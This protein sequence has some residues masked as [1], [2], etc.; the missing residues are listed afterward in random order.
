MGGRANLMDMKVA[1]GSRLDLA[2]LVLMVP[3]TVAWDL[4]DV[5]VYTLAME[6]SAVDEDENGPGE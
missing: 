5:A 3:D 4:V 2:A 1:V 6:V